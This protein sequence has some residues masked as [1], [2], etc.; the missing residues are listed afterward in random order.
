MGCV[1]PVEFKIPVPAGEEN[2]I[3]QKINI[4][5]EYEKDGEIMSDVNGKK[6]MDVIIE[7]MGGYFNFK[8]NLLFTKAQT[9]TVGIEL[10]LNNGFTYSKRFS[11]IRI[12]DNTNQDINIYKLK[13]L[14]RTEIDYVL[15]NG[16]PNWNLFSFTTLKESD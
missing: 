2:I 6:S 11:G 7:P 14:N 12:L 9:Y 1:V 13:K 15:S 3:I 5:K 10:I 16:N 4:T 8:F